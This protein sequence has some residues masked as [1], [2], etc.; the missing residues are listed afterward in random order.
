MIPHEEDRLPDAMIIPFVGIPFVRQIS[1]MRCGS[2]TAE[3]I[4]KAMGFYIKSAN[5]VLSGP[6]WHDY[7]RVIL[8]ATILKLLKIRG[9]EGIVTN[10]DAVLSVDQKI[11]WLRR[12]LYLRKKPIILLVRTNLLHWVVLAGYDDAKKVF[13]IYDPNYGDT[14]LNSDLPIGNRAYD[15]DRLV[16]LWGGKWGMR[17]MI[18]LILNEY[19]MN[20]ETA[21]STPVSL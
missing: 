20:E 7:L 1:H 16:D 19:V 15:Y 14:S 17:F 13:Y 12:E 2:Y 8:P 18:V 5:D 10:V 21:H 9:I 6:V 11:D 3:W 4:S